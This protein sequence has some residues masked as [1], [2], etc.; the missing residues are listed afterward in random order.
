MLLAAVDQEQHI[1]KSPEQN[2]NSDL[3]SNLKNMN[4]LCGFQEGVIIVLKMKMFRLFRI[5]NRNKD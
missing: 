1:A 5:L 2:L 4:L 3:K